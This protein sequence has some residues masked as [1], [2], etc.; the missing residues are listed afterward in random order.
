MTRY[1]GLAPSQRVASTRAT[2]CY[3]TKVGLWEEHSPE[4]VPSKAATLEICELIA[5]LE[6][7]SQ[8][9]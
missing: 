8:A 2:L 1:R 7:I 3:E 9:R 6:P 4:P 5:Y